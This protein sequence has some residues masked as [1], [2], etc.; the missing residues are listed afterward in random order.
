MGVLEYADTY[1][2]TVHYLFCRDIYRISNTIEE[3]V[4]EC[5]RGDCLPESRVRHPDPRD[6]VH[7]DLQEGSYCLLLLLTPVELILRLAWPETL[8]M[9][10][11]CCPFKSY[12]SKDCVKK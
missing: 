11:Q 3:L 2:W 4:L 9:E 1:M 12:C 7:T 5:H 10:S 6:T 8:L